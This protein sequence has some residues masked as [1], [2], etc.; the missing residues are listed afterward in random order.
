MKSSLGR[1]LVY[2]VGFLLAGALIYFFAFWRPNANRVEQLE[3]DI[4]S[5][6][7]TLADAAQWGE[8][9]P[10]LEANLALLSEQLNQEQSA[11]E[12]VSMEWQND[13]GRFLPEIFDE[14][15]IRQRIEYIVNPYSSFMDVSFHY[16]QPMGAM[17]YNDNN[18]YGPP[19][20]IWMTP[21]NVAFAA[22]YNGIMAILNGFAHEGFDNRIVAFNLA[23]Q[24]NLWLVAMRL[25]ILS[26]TPSPSG[27][28]G[29]YIIDGSDY[30]HSDYYPDGDDYHSDYYPDGDDYH[31]DYY[32]GSDDYHN[33]YHSD[34]NEYHSDYHP[35]SDGHYDGDHYDE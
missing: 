22:D 17:S 16:S 3:R 18:P 15:S 9:L 24:G 28:N 25:D 5:A 30:H 11:W 27:Y 2:T 19:E 35:D 10:Q 32:S 13:Y 12:Y 23:R 7:I 26:R 6:R 1:F 4:A 14:A 34:G 29:D 21:I 33:D 20:G 8:R 31:D